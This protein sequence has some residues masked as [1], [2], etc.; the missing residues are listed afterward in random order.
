MMPVSKHHKKKMSNSQWK[1]RRN[2]KKMRR[3]WLESIKREWTVKGEFLI[4]SIKNLKP[5]WW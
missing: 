4:N 3:Q 5:N 1:K 2:K